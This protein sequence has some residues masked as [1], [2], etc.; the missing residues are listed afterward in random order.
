MAK[1]GLQKPNEEIVSFNVFASC[2]SVIKE[3]RNILKI[4]TKEINHEKTSIMHKRLLCFDQFKK[5]SSFQMKSLKKNY[6]ANQIY[7]MQIDLGIQ[8]ENI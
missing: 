6:K 5:K 2:A 7:I 3:D 8:E 4:K 1:D